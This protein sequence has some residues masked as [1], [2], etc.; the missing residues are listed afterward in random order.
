MSP[1]LQ[2][3]GAGGKSHIVR[4]DAFFSGLYAMLAKDSAKTGTG[5]KRGGGRGDAKGPRRPRGLG[6]DSDGPGDDEPEDDNGLGDDDGLG[7]GDAVD[8]GAE[9]QSD[10]GEEHITNRIARTS[11]GRPPCQAKRMGS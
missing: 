6:C 2:T 9:L 7:D 5:C 1:E 4:D 11:N 8:S 10:H 3:C